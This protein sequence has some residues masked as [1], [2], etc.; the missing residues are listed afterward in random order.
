M[1]DLPNPF[2]RPQ[3]FTSRASFGPRDAGCTPLNYN[4]RLCKVIE[5]C[6]DLFI[7]YVSEFQE[8][9]FLI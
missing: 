7:G 5:T 3:S 4:L 8:V 2:R 9:T 6:S 1:I